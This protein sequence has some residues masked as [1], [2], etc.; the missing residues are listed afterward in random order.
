[1]KKLIIAIDGHAATGK[2][3]QAKRLA[4]KL[5]YVYVDTGAMYR[6][7][8][9]FAY[10]QEPI[11]EIDYNLLQQ[12]LDQIQIHFEGK[13]DAQQIFLNGTEVTTAIRKPEINNLVSQVAAKEPIRFFLKKLQRELG[14]N[15]GIVMDGRDIGTVVFPE[16]ACKFFL[17]ANANVRAQRRYE[18]QLA[19]GHEE[20]F[21]AVLTNLKN[22]D[23]LDETR[24]VAPLKKAADAVEIDVSNQTI[25]EVFELL[26]A[27]VLEKLAL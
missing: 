22:R 16:A 2:S 19:Q 4:K 10:Q 27:Q 20:S 13:A 9:L 7:I 15:K 25:E 24:S 1:M 3:T 5:G 23:A 18:E 26:Y 8:T 14:A 6:A 17:T 12:S 11:G 21:E